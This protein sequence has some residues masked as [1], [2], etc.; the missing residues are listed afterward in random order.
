M[1]NAIQY[2]TEKMTE[3]SNLKPKSEI[4]SLSHH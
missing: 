1:I 3:N 4:V 2:G